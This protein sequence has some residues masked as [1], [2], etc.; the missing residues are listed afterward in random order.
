MSPIITYDKVKTY[1]PTR[2]TDLRFQL[3]FVPPKK[4]RFFEQYIDNTTHIENYVI[5]IKHREIKSVSEGIEITG[6][7]FF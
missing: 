5:L 2:I 4:N 7:E 1:Y 3:E 6:V